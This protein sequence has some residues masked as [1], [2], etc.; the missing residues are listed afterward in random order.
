MAICRQKSRQ[1][2]DLPRHR[3]QFSL[4]DL[5]TWITG[6]AFWLSLLKCSGSWP[7]A[8]SVGGIALAVYGDWRFGLLFPDKYLPITVLAIIVIC[9]VV[10]V[11]AALLFPAVR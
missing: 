5:L 6:V 2:S 3:L 1:R 11:F 9:V 8:I 7:L 10:G 4:A